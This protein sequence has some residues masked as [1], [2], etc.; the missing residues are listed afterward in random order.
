[1]RAEIYSLL[2]GGVLGLSTTEL[3]PV[4]VLG[5]A[6][7]AGIVLLYR[8]LLLSSVVPEVAE[9]GGI[10]GQRVE[11]CFPVGFFAGAVSYGLGR[12]CAA[13]LRTQAISHCGV[14]APVGFDAGLRVVKR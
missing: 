10:R 5:A 8:P 3:L 12:A 9:A 14:P 13:W 2:F 4:A 11:T 6:C 1:M 7:V